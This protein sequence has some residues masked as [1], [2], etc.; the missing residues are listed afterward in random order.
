M[1][2]DSLSSAIN[3]VTYG[4]FIIHPNLLLPKFFLWYS[5]RVEFPEP[6]MTHVVLFFVSKLATEACLPAILK[7]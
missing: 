6:L 7:E 3:T 4:P 2:S 5:R 1:F